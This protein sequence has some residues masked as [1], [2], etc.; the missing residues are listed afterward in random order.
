MNGD[1][2]TIRIGNATAAASSHTAARRDTV[3]SGDDSSTTGSSVIADIAQSETISTFSSAAA[4]AGS[5]SGA[6]K[7]TSARRRS[8]VPGQMEVPTAFR[9]GRVTANEMS[10]GTAK[11]P[12]IPSRKPKPDM[13]AFGSVDWCATTA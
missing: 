7:A 2:S 8:G 9:L 12:A 1:T 13:A 5:T 4:I 6:T 10:T 3:S 11:Y